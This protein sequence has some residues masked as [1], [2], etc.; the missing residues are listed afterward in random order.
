M[1]Q[2]ALAAKQKEEDNLTLEKYKRADDMKIKEL[3]LQLEKLTIEKNKRETELEK[4][5]TQTQAFQIEIDKTAAEFK[6]QHEERH[7]IFSQW[8]EAIQQIEKRHR[9]TLHASEE[10]A[11]IKMEMKANQAYLDERKRHLE[12]ERNVNKNIQE[13]TQKRERQITNLK[14]INKQSRENEMELNA[15]V[16]IDQNRL[17]ASSSELAKKKNKVQMLQR[18]LLVRK[19]RLTNAEKRYKAQNSILKNENNLD[20]KLRA[21]NDNAKNRYQQL[22][23]KLEKKDKEIRQK[24]DEYFKAQQKLFKLRENEANLYSE[25]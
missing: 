9:A 6:K 7:K 20:A 4:E 2:W 11:R 18:E 14:E 13:E 10:M 23:D 24:K 15:E 22:Q 17:S 8:D 16:K 5:V 1:E 12:E 25:I 19:E 21:M 3:S